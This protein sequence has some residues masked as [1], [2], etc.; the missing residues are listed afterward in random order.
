VSNQT[1]LLLNLLEGAELLGIQPAQLYEHTRARSRARQRIPIPYL[2]LG[3]RLAFRRESL[4]R[5]ICQLE[6]EK[7]ALHD[8]HAL[9][10]AD[11]PKNEEVTR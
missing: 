9:A 3:R 11:A 10:V 1:K 7:S 5:W 8:E 4:E 2:Q 6:A